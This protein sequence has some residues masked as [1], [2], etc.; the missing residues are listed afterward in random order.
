MEHEYEVVVVMREDTSDSDRKNL[1][2]Q[3][4]KTI[5]SE[6]GKV[7]STQDWG[8]RELAYKIQK[9]SHGFYSHITFKS[10]S[11]TPQSLNS[12]FKLTSELLRYLILRKESEKTKG[13]EKT[14]S[15]E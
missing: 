14:K 12:K 8:K 11:K 5:E 10:N 13:K 3:I 9:N 6:K 2:D 4:E 1:L 7:I 15:G